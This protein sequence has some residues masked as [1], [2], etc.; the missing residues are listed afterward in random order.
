MSFDY[1]RQ[2]GC[3]CV[4]PIRFYSFGFIAAVL[5]SWTPQPSS[6]PRRSCAGTACVAY[7]R[8]KSRPLGGRPWLI[9]Q[10]IQINQILK[11]SFENACPRLMR[12]IH[13]QT[14]PAHTVPPL[15]VRTREPERISRS[16][17]PVRRNRGASLIPDKGCLWGH[18]RM[19]RVSQLCPLHCALQT[20]FARSEDFES[21]AWT[22]SRPCC[23]A[24]P[25]CGS[26][27]PARK[28]PAKSP[29]IK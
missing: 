15:S 29:G 9:T 20:R 16:L 2:V 6:G 5:A 7:W 13:C 24:I 8:W 10:R 17:T 22:Q 18:T 21:R 26:I 27:T 25:A 11:Q 14:L 4:G 12:A 23:S 28:R 3:V 19:H 1:A